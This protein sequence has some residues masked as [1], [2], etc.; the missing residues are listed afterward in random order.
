MEKTPLTLEKNQ[1]PMLESRIFAGVKEKL[2]TRASG[3]LMQE[4]YLLGLVTWK[5][6]RERERELQEKPLAIVTPNMHNPIPI[7]HTTVIPTTIDRIPPNT[8]HS[9][10]SA[11]LYVFEDNEA[12]IKMIIKGRSP[13]MRHVSRTPQS[14]SGLVV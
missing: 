2:L 8:T 10:S 1:Q 4:Q 7:K 6:T 3:N 13:T 11:V 12:V 5:V 14:C 9:D